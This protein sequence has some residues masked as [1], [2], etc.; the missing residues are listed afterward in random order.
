MD[1]AC[2]TLDDVVPVDRAVGL[3]KMDVEGA[4]LRVL[5]GGARV[6]KAHHPLIIFEATKSG[7]T[8]NH[9]SATDLYETLKS[10]GYS[11]RTPR[12]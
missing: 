7:L 5:R 6:L 11:I 2:E 1:V 3:I 8:S 10:L 12:G 9:I 4:E